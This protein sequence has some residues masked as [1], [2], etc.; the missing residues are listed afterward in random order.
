LIDEFGVTRP[1]R[2]FHSGFWLSLR[3]FP[4][5]ILTLLGQCHCYQQKKRNEEKNPP[6]KGEARNGNVSNEIPLGSSKY[7]RKYRLN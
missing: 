5:F 6:T 7:R 1:L 4:Y 2:T 3:Y